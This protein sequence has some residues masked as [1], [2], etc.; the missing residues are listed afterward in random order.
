MIIILV[1][2]TN[3]LNTVIVPSVSIYLCLQILKL[4][5][6]E[7]TKHHRGL[8]LCLLD[9]ILVVFSHLLKFLLLIIDLSNIVSIQLTAIGCRCS[10][11]K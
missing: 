6:F 5:I 2:Q 8:L 9:G 10:L 11:E 4:L 7:L 1:F 3:A